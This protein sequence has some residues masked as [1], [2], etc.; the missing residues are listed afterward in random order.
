MV[1]HPI[2]VIKTN[3]SSK[4]SPFLKVRACAKKGFVQTSKNAGLKFLFM[5]DKDTHSVGYSNIH[6]FYKENNSNE[7]N[8]IKE[9]IYA[10]ARIQHGKLTTLHAYLQSVLRNDYR[11]ILNGFSEIETLSFVKNMPGFLDILSNIYQ[12]ARQQEQFDQ[13]DDIRDYVLLLRNIIPHLENLMQ[14][15]DHLNKRFIKEVITQEK[16]ALSNSP[17]S[18]QSFVD[19]LYVHLNIFCLYGRPRRDDQGLLYKERQHPDAYVK[20]IGE[21]KNMASYDTQQAIVLL[22]SVNGERKCEFVPKPPS[23][24]T[25]GGRN[26]ASTTQVN[27]I[28]TDIKVM[29]HKGLR[30]VHTVG[31]KKSDN[32][33]KIS[34]AWVRV[35]TTMRVVQE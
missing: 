33:V 1:E 28:K 16:I 12:R 25:S 22:D 31:K 2:P 29:T 5:V 6:V 27:F 18:F 23:V 4:L 10:D 26:E 14:F 20:I 7:C 15:M 17:V 30:C 8:W 34:N 3:I 19:A 24:R 9:I 35:D 21:L 11:N 13:L 32:Y